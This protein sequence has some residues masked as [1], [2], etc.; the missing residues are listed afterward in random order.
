MCPSLS[1]EVVVSC[2]D[3]VDVEANEF[4][5]SFLTPISVMKAL[6]FSVLMRLAIR[7]ITC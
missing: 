7:S 6:L 2:R 3:Y 4:T 1:S 5:P